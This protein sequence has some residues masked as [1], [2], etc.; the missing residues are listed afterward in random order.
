MAREGGG[1]RP[2]RHAWRIGLVGDRARRPRPP[3]GRG[4]SSPRRA[5][6]RSRPTTG[7]ESSAT[8]RARSSRSSAATWSSVPTPA[9]APRSPPPRAELGRSRPIRR[10]SALLPASPRAAYST[11]ICQSPACGGYSS[12]SPAWPARSGRCSTARR[13]PAR[14]SRS[15]RP[16]VARTC[17]CTARSTPTRRGPAGPAEWVHTRRLHPAACGVDVDARRRRAQ[18]IRARAAPCR[19]DRGLRRQRRAAA[20][21]AGVRADRRGRQRPQSSRCSV[22]RPRWRCRLARR[23]RC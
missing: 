18:P 1:A 15:R 14:R 12:R 4:G 17:G 7:S 2:A 16:R 11:P 21:P 5:P 19:S 3:R 6:A 23:R 8:A 22:A 9:S 13:S 10:T 20:R